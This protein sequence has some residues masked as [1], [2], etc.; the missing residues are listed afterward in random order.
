MSWAG[1]RRRLWTVAAVALAVAGADQLTKALAVW[2]IPPGGVSLVPGYVDLVLVANPGAAFG[3]L[4]GLNGARWVLAAAAAV[5]VVLG[6]WLAATHKA[7]VG[8]ALGLIVGGAAGNLI[9][10]LRLGHVVDFVDLHWGELHWPAFNLA[11]AAITVG[12]VWLGWQLVR[13]S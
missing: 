8:G 3:L 5:A 6:L 7:G 4:A 10:R 9:D 2:L 13:R 1:A 12:A 11:D